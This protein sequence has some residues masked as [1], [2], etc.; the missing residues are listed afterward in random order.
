M[1]GPVGQ[2]GDPG[3]LTGYPLGF[4]PTVRFSL[5]ITVGITVR[6]GTRPTGRS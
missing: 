2:A 5:R 4:I 6:L 3:I 1:F